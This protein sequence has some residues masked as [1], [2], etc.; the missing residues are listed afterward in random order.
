MQ[1]AREGAPRYR[2]PVTE[3][4]G[5]QAH[6]M[7]EILS[8]AMDPEIQHGYAKQYETCMRQKIRSGGT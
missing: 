7:R 8:R 3:A 1:A 4:A 5:D 2:C 6:S